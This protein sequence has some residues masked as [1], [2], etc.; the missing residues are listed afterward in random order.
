MKFF[1]VNLTTQFHQTELL[2]SKL[3]VC[4]KINSH[5]NIHQVEISISFFSYC[6]IKQKNIFYKI[7]K[8]IS[9]ISLSYVSLK[10]FFLFF[11]LFK[12]LI[13]FRVKHWDVSTIFSTIIPFTG[14]S[15]G[16]CTSS[17][18]FLE[19]GKHGKLEGKTVG[20]NIS[21]HPDLSMTFMNFAY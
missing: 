18:I 17:E 4:E 1:V 20:S 7:I 21:I 19:N 16:N 3:L 15:H 12:C 9:N 6:A 11:V 10:Y 2:F 5:F 8:S 14:K 13:L